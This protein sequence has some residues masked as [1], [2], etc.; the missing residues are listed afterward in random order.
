MSAF[1]NE[2]TNPQA[3]AAIKLTLTISA[4]VVVVNAIFG[5]LIAWVLVRDEFP[6]KSIVNSVID[7]PFALPT[8][9][10]GIAL[11]TLYG[12]SGWIGAGLARQAARPRAPPATAAT[13]PTARTA[14]TSTPAGPGSSVLT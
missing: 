2:V 13:E 5:T 4:I 7:L 14:G 9:V 6:G 3:Q 8:A 10:A 11:A 12:P 1:W